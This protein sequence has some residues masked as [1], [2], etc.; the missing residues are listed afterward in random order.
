MVSTRA[1]ITNRLFYGDNLDI[2]RAHVADA[3]VDLVYLDPP[4]NSNA[5]YNGNCSRLRGLRRSATDNLCWSDLTEQAKIA[6]DPIKSEQLLTTF[7]SV[8]ELV[9]NPRRRLKRSPTLG[10]G[11]RKP[12]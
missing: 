11:R 5:T 12:R 7:C 8:N 6:S 2:L 1:T 4:F 3:S 9:K 10:N